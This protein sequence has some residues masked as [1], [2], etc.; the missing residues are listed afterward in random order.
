MCLGG[1]KHIFCSDCKSDCVGTGY[2]IYTPAWVLDLKTNRHLDSMMHLYMEF[3][4]KKEDSRFDSKEELKESLLLQPT[5]SCESPPVNESRC[6]GR[7]T[8]VSL[9]LAEHIVSPDNVSKSE[10]TSERKDGLCIPPPLL[11]SSAH[12][13]M[14]SNPCTVKLSP[15][16]MDRKKKLQRREFASYCFY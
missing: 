3:K 16:I 4:A 15:N 8:K 1:C 10:K 12:R 2:P 9:P 5:T 13:Q 6:S 11:H 7:L 14:M